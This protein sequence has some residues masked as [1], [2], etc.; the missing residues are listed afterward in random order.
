MMNP[1]FH[2]IAQSGFVDNFMSQTLFSIN[3]YKMSFSDHKLPINALLDHFEQRS[4]LYCTKLYT[5]PNENDEK[6]AK[7]CSSHFMCMK[8]RVFLFYTRTNYFCKCKKEYTDD[9]R[10][11]LTKELETVC[12]ICF[13]KCE[14]NTKCTD[15]VKNICIDCGFV[16]KSN[17]NKCNICANRSCSSCQTKLDLFFI[18]LDSG[19]LIHPYCSTF[20]E[21]C[22][23]WS[24]K[25]FES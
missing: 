3:D 4:C 1:S 22:Q 10:E 17:E 12:M 7:M 24:E 2:F 15:C 11:E 13:R 19:H 23:K 5:I 18:I 25:N 14:E 21:K 20:D 16:Y 6:S 8:C 9:E